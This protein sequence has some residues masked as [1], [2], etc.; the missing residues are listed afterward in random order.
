MLEWFFEAPQGALWAAG[1]CLRN[2]EVWKQELGCF[3][4]RW[5]SLKSKGCL[6]SW[7][8]FKAISELSVT[9]VLWVCTWCWYLVGELLFPFSARD[10]AFRGIWKCFEGMVLAL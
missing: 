7:R 6:R 1:L 4:A 5:V 10:Y 9:V 8:R 3:D 2:A